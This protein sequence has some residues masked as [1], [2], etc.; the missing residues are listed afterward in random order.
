VIILSFGRDERMST[1]DAKKPAAY[2]RSVTMVH[3]FSRSPREVWQAWTDPV[4][5]R[6]WF[7]SDPGGRV[8][9]ARIDLRVGGS[10]EVRFAN[11]DG[12]EHTCMGTYLEIEQ[13]WKLAFTWTWKDRP[14]VMEQVTVTLE[15]DNAGTLMT[16]EHADIDS[17]TSHDYAPGW[18]RTFQKLERALAHP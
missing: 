14:D 2:R 7:G 8:L 4:V 16:F 5:A 17:G 12:T 13:E 15:P 18:K 3:R 1:N 11:S 10:F 9:D 6:M